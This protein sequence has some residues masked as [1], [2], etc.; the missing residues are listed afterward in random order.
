MSKFIRKFTQS[1][2]N[3]KLL[4]RLHTNSKAVGAQYYLLEA[5]SNISARKSPED[6]IIKALCALGYK[7]PQ[8]D[9]L[10][11]LLE[12]KKQVWEKI[13]RSLGLAR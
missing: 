1:T 11:K 5:V 8:I 2:N 12:N 7:E 13:D 3:L 9:R 6:S 10:I 4:C